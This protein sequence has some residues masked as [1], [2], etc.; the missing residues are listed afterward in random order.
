VGPAKPTDKLD[1]DVDD[2]LYLK[3]AKPTVF[4]VYNDNFPLYIKHED[5]SEI[6]HGG[7][8]LNISVIQLWILRMTETS[9]RAGN[10]D[11]YGFLELQSIQKS[12]QSQFESESYI[13]NWMQNSR[14]DVYL[15]AYLNESD[16]YLKGII[17]SALKGLDD[18]PQ[19]KSKAA[20]RWIVVKYFNDV[21][22]FEL[23]RLKAL[24]IQEYDIKCIID[25]HA[26]L[27]SQNGMEHS[28]SIDG[29]TASKDPSLYGIDEV[30]V[31]NQRK[32]TSDTRTQVNNNKSVKTLKFDGKEIHWEIGENLLL[33]LESV[34]I[35]KQVFPLHNEK[36]R[37]KLLRSWALQWWDFTSQP[38]DEIYSYY[39]A[40]K[41][42]LG[43]L[44]NFGSMALDR[45]HNTLKSLVFCCAFP[46]AFAFAAVNNLMEIR[47]DALKLLV[48]LRRP[49]PRVV[50]RVGVWLNIFQF[51]ILMSICTNCA[52]LAWLYDEEG[53]WKIEPGLAAILI[54][55]HVLLLTKFGFS[56]F[57]PKVIVLLPKMSGPQEQNLHSQGGSGNMVIVVLCRH[58]ILFEHIIIVLTQI[59]KS[60]PLF[61]SSK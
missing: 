13:K 43:M 6:A 46:L 57:F 5:L 20:A 29:F 36:K 39:G 61:I 11:V 7:Q 44:T 30:E 53:K 3:P 58:G 45:I 42:I 50:A 12:G 22:P 21:R 54:M 10:A 52:I 47:T 24:R 1:H 2:P 34:E 23:E 59:F 8:C 25:F 4:G 31:K 55:E 28:A 49:V 16:N 9:M 27:G 51:L 19:S 18:T 41:F 60:G 33:K 14:R 35:V 48:I 38:I 40:K 26:A 56:R 32:W 17:S 37:K 15:G